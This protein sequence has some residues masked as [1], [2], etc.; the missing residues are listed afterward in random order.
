MLLYHVC[1]SGHTGRTPLQ[2]FN[3]PHQRKGDVT[4]KRA[5]SW[6]K[7]VG[8]TCVCFNLRGKPETLRLCTHFPLI[9]LHFRDPLRTTELEALAAMCGFLH[10]RCFKALADPHSTV[11]FG[12]L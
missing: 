5:T 8:Y 6:Q 9:Q 4:D 1:F 3:V 10:T 2:T 11:A 7:A 12:M